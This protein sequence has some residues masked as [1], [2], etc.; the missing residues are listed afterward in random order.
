MMSWTI[1]PSLCLSVRVDTWLVRPANESDC[2]I[3]DCDF[4][5]TRV[6]TWRLFLSCQRAFSICLVP[7]F[8]GK[9]CGIHDT[10]FQKLPE[11]KR[12]HLQ[13]NVVL[14]SFIGTLSGIHDTSFQI[15]MNATSTPAKQSGG[16][17][18][19]KRIVEHM[20]KELTDLFHY[21]DRMSQDR[22]QRSAER[23]TEELAY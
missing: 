8:I 22:F 9:E 6:L 17:T 13:D 21:H 7:S 11:V 18:M 15:F 3:T 2:T 12:L 16:T 23:M 14:P 4:H 1:Y 10:S 20:T 19:F 5:M